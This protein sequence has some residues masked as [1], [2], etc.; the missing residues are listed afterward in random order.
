MKPLRLVLFLGFS[1][2]VACSSSPT[3][4]DAG[5]GSTDS[6]MPGVDAGSSAPDAGGE[7]TFMLATGDCFTFATASS[8]P[9]NSHTCG[10]MLALAGANVDI[11]GSSFCELPGTFTSLASVP[12]SYASCMWESYVEGGNGLANHGLI[13][14]D[15]AQAHHYRVRIVSNTLPTLVFSFAQID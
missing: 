6:G 1:F 13:V 4:T 2:L 12:T 8:M 3:P 10:D 5:A 14:L 9:S 7:T 11:G 15:A